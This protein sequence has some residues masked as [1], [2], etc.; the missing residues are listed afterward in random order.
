VVLPVGMTTVTLTVSDGTLSDSDTADIYVVDTMS[1]EID[2]EVPVPDQA[3]QDGVTLRAM[4]S[5]LSGVT[6]VYFY[7]REPGGPQG[8]PIGFEGLA[9]SLKSGSTES[10]VWEY[11]FDTTQLPDG[12]YVVLAKAVDYYSNEGW[13][14][15]IP[16][17]IQNW[18]ILELLPASE[19]NKAGRTIPVKFSLRIAE[20]V[21]PSQPFVYNEELEIRIY[22]EADPSTILQTSLYGD[23]SKDYRIDSAGELYITNFKTAKKPARYVVEI[24]RTS[25][26]FLIGSFT[27]ETVK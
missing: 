24:W 8:V 21:D 25:K 15:V 17:S 6:G 22:D 23:T 14:Y 3:L 1:P 9:A 7:I 2:I 5:D 13:S 16:L 12:Y 20:S 27:F 19:S 10:G 26:N 11:Q 4:A 18:A